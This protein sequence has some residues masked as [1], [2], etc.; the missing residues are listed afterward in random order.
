MYTKGIIILIFFFSNTLE[1][2]WE[3]I[4]NL[5]FIFMFAPVQT[6]ITAPFYPQQEVYNIFF[7]NLLF[8]TP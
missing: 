4:A 2:V 5:H 6:I 3:E 7:N 1:L 8:Y